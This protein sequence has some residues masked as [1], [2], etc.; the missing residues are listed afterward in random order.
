[1]S[2]P[3]LELE[4]RLRQ[5]APAFK[6]GIEAPATLHVSVMAHTTAPRRPARRPSMLRELSLAAALIAFVAL[7][8]FGFSRL[9]S[10]V[11]GPVKRSP[12]PS[13]VSRVVPWVS[14]TPTPLKL[15]AP[16]TLTVDQAAQ[17][18]RQTVTDVTPVLLPSAIPSG[19]QVQLYDDS[20]GFSASYVAADG[21]KIMF[22]IAVPNPAPGTANARQSQPMFRGVRADY[23][24]D[25]GTVPTS[26]RW[27]IW[28]EPGTAVGGQSV[29]PYFLTTDGFAE[30]EFW[31]IANSIGPIP[32]PVMPPTCRLADLYVGSLGGNGAGGHIISAIGI[33]NH[34]KAACSLIGFPGVSLVTSQGSTLQLP[35]QQA[36]GGWAAPSPAQPAILL[37]NQAA[38]VSHTP[39]D[40]ASFNFEWYYC[41]GTTPPVTAADITLPG[42]AGVRRV[43]FGGLDTGSRCDTPA[44]GRMLLI[45]A[46][47]GP[48]LE[49]IA[50]TP[51][52]VRVTLAGVPDNL[53]AG[54]TLRYEV[55]I[56]N[57]SAAAISFDTC[58]AYD[59]GFTPDGMVS[60]LLNCTPVGRLEAGASTTFAMEF[61]IRPWPKAPTGQQK[62]MW[63]LHADYGSASAGKVVTVSAS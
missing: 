4:E 62:F 61:T 12:S 19:F 23:Q 54:Q 44:Q 57:D 20:G 27:L 29:V 6:D 50:V 10:V 25:D 53:V 32:A 59:E 52:A 26:H 35:E 30:T 9:H 39:V 33:T 47:Q 8:A 34:G 31:T 42:V 28:N 63:R 43:A 58:P 24:V 22:S 16:K 40:G 18:V 46:I 1:M 5:L 36:S 49:S 41:D 17:D 7:L 2:G 55:T 37:P 48:N 38:P 51:P 3:D 21:R 56:T 45:G 11:P 15:Q 14:T 13:P 60:Y